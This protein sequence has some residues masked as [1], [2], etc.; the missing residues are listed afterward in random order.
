MIINITQGDI[1]VGVRNEPSLCAIAQAIIRTVP[2]GVPVHVGR[3]TIDVGN[4]IYK[5]SKKAH[6]FI[7]T[8]D[9]GRKETLKPTKMRLS[10]I[11]QGELT[12]T[13]AVK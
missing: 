8:F 13:V 9:F 5:V 7:Q 2:V 11:Q 12:T 1:D 3:E 6:T 4:K 10:P